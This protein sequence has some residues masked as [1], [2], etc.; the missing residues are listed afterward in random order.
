MRNARLNED[1]Y[2]DSQHRAVPCTRAA[3]TL[4]ATTCTIGWSCDG[5]CPP[6]PEVGTGASLVQVEPCLLLH[7]DA[8]IY[9]TTAAPPGAAWVNV[10]QARLARTNNESI[11]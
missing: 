5:F 9:W 10:E 6:R 4:A 3:S 11:V 8:Q 7:A 2:D 1:V